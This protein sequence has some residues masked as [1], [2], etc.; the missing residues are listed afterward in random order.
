MQGTDFDRARWAFADAAVLELR[1]GFSPEVYILMM[2]VLGTRA[3]Q[4]LWAQAR[5][6]RWAPSGS[7]IPSNS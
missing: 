5:G 4:D 6:H 1:K 7:F 3:Q 2:Q